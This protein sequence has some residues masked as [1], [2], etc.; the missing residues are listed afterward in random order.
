MRKISTMFGL[1]AD[2]N[3]LVENSKTSRSVFDICPFAAISN[4]HQPCLNSLPQHAR[5]YF[6]AINRRFTAESWKRAPAAAHPEE[7][8][9]IRNSSTGCL[10]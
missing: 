10:A 3:T 9:K 2:K 5:Q 1:L 6:N 4:H 8:A 7:Q